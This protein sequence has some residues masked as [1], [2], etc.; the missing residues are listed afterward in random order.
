MLISSQKEKKGIIIMD[1]TKNAMILYTSNLTPNLDYVPLV[2]EDIA[3]GMYLINPFGDIYSFHNEGEMK[4][5]YNK[6]YKRINLITDFGRRPFSVHR[7][8][9]HTFVVNLF[10][11]L[12]NDVNHIDGNKANNV[13]TNL[14]WCSNKQNMS[15]ALEM[16]LRDYVYSDEFAKEICQRFQN[17]EKYIDVYRYYQ[18]LYPDSRN[19]IGSFIYKLY[20]RKTRELITSQYNY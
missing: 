8:V 13:Y 18:S 1:N 14:E 7:L 3:K 12:Y 6:G 11:D 5:Y 19:T 20:N 4:Q 17:G 2:Y 15:Y 16:G 9:A 10:P